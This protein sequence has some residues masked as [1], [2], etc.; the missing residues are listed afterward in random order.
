[1]VATDPLTVDY[2]VSSSAH[3]ALFIAVSLAVLV[4]VLVLLV[5]WSRRSAAHS[6]GL[7]YSQTGQPED[8]IDPKSSP[9]AMESWLKG[10]KLGNEFTAA[11]ALA[12]TH[13]DGDEG[14]R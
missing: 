14:Q 8:A 2:V 13:L 5:Q 9:R 1:M 4:A 3:L 7:R 6:A 10:Y 11:G 12:R